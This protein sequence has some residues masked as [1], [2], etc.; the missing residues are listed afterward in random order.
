MS[1]NNQLDG[2]LLARHDAHDVQQRRNY[3]PL[4]LRVKMALDLIDQKNDFLSGLTSTIST[5]FLMG[6]PSPYEHVSQRGDPTHTRRRMNQRHILTIR[7]FQ[8]W[9]ASLIRS[10][11]FARLTRQDLL[12]TR[13]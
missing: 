3:P 13:G 5:G 4:P 9:I 8:M 1:S 2:H 12:D 6:I 11:Q 7:H 10:Y